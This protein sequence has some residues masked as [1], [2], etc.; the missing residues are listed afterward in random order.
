[1]EGHYRV[2]SLFPKRPN[3]TLRPAHPLAVV[4]L[5]Q[6]SKHRGNWL[7][8]SSCVQ[9]GGGGGGGEERLTKDL[10]REAN[11]LSRNTRQSSALGLEGWPPPLEN[12][13]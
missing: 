6:K 7:F 5:I 10:K 13:R 12:C 1:M 2:R 4:E 8:F 9:G 3:H 11:S